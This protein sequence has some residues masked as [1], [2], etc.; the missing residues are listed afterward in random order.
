MCLPEFARAVEKT[1]RAQ[2]IVRGQMLVEGG[3]PTV[4]YAW[5]FVL[6][7]SMMLMLRAEQILMVKRLR[8]NA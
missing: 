1:K 3:E 4:G 5:F 8:R 6:L 2:E 7:V